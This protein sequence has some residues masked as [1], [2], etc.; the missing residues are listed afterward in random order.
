MGALLVS[1]A[2]ACGGGGV[3]EAEAGRTDG[4]ATDAGPGR[5]TGEANPSA[6]LPGTDAVAEPARV[7][8]VYSWSERS[9][10]TFT[11]KGHTI[12][13]LDNYDPLPDVKFVF[14]GFKEANIVDRSADGVE[15]T[16]FDCIGNDDLHCAA[17]DP[18]VSPDN[19][20]IAFAV[21]YG[22]R[23]NVA[24][25]TIH[26]TLPIPV[27]EGVETGQ[28]FIYDVTAGT[29]SGWPRVEGT[30]DMHPEWIS[31]DELVFVS[32][33]AKV[34]PVHLYGESATY[35]R[36]FALQRWT[37]RVD[38]ADATNI[39]P[40]DDMALHP[41]VLSDGNIV[42][43]LWRA[44]ENLHVKETSHNLYWMTMTDQFGGNE[45]TLLGAHDK[46]FSNAGKTEGLIAL[47][48]YGELSN[49]D[50]ATGNYY[51]GRHLGLGMPIAFPRLPH[52]VEGGGAATGT[53]FLPAI[54]SLLPWAQEEDNPTHR[55]AEGR[56][57]GKGGYPVGLPGGQVLLTKGT[58]FCYE[59]LKPELANEAY[60][61][62]PGCD[63]GIYVLP[64]IPS[65]HPDDLV[66][67]VD[68]PD[69]H[70]FSAD[71][72]L[73]YSRT[74]GRAAPARQT[75]QDQGYC[76]LKVVDVRLSRMKS[77]G[78]P[79]TV[80]GACIRPGYDMSALARLAIYE[81]IPSR[82]PQTTLRGF[83]RDGQKLSLLGYATPEADGSVNVRIPCDTP[84]KLR[85]VAADGVE[86]VRDQVKHSNRPG[87]GRQCLG[88]HAGHTMDDYQ[89]DVAGRFALTLAGSKPAVPLEPR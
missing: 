10:G 6:A 16:L 2:V 12:T 22:K 45:V 60:L 5:T 77:G 51:R 20:K 14:R 40:H 24:R 78:K 8:V 58:G 83:P 28:I 79:C 65:R 15:T 55:D 13:A 7:P 31:N 74:Y 41:L 59:G 11:L 42:T 23:I 76:S 48:F 63:T 50:L 36:Q 4:A 21:L 80:K 72:R 25:W 3:S 66:K 34:Y 88:C 84:Y 26:G 32:N 75:S 18:R 9:T 43:A 47:H 37:A 86:F 70:E 17:L 49:G 19:T 57:M 52:G 33:R 38:G 44:D 89:P 39:G 87:E 64:S 61:K 67:V 62:G 71:V 81:A 68:R 82:T 1:L 46:H 85:G 69:R 35:G 29:L 53:G 73:P 27:L 30:I 56:F 54:Y